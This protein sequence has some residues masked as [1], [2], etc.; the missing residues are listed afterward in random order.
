MFIAE[1]ALLYAL[2]FDFAVQHAAKVGHRAG[3]ARGLGA[4]HGET[5]VR[6]CPPNRCACLKME[7]AFRWQLNLT[8]HRRAGPT[9]A[10]SPPRRMTA[11]PRVPPPAAQP[12]IQMWQQEPLRSFRR[13]LRDVQKEQQLV[14]L[15]YSLSN[16]WCAA[17]P[18]PS[19][20]ARARSPTWGR[21]QAVG[22]LPG[23]WPGAAHLLYPLASTLLALQGAAAGAASVLLATTSIFYRPAVVTSSEQT[24]RVTPKAHA[25][26]LTP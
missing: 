26:T 6:L 11:P 7:P 24:G 2:D 23:W 9:R 14:Q 21:A 19:P 4:A 17:P 8:V 16:D 10:V 5:G 22:C 20:A 18:P 15:A 12:L 25:W 13:G 1:R 3:G